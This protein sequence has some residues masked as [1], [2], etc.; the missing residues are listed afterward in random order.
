[1]NTKM[2][3]KMYLPMIIMVILT[4]C[5]DE[6]PAVQS[7][8]LS[9]LISKK[10]VDYGNSESLTSEYIYGDEGKIIKIIESDKYNGG[11]ERDETWFTYA[12]GQ[13]TEVTYYDEDVKEDLLTKVF[14]ENN[15]LSKITSSEPDYYEEF[16]FIYQGEKINKVEVFEGDNQDDLSKSKFITFTYTGENITKTEQFDSRDNDELKY[17]RTYTYDEAVNPFYKNYAWFIVKLDYMELFSEAN[18]ITLKENDPV[19]EE[20]TSS[21]SYDYNEQNLPISLK[22]STFEVSSGL[23]GEN[24]TTFSYDCK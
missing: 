18:V 17:L 20:Y 11:V 7:D 3:M 1:M 21:N 16:R 10:V 12:D 19:E 8:P 13:I 14:Y 9:C 15:K 4:S 2:R 6:E 24:P 22:E 5:T 23:K